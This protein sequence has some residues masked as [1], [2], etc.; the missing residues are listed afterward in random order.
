MK[1]IYD[2]L[3]LIPPGSFLE[4]AI[5]ALVPTIGTIFL[6]LILSNNSEDE[7]EEDWR[8]VQEHRIQE[9]RDAQIRAQREHDEGVRIDQES[10]RRML[11]FEDADLRRRQ[12]LTRRIN[13]IH[14]GPPVAEPEGPRTTINRGRVT[15]E[16]EKHG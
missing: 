13:E 4:W 15:L 7:E 16:E 3:S 11:P 1:F 8:L 2:V 14:G 10:M 6:V 12:L 9:L 5:P